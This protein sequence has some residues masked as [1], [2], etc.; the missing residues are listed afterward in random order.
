MPIVLS[1]C[2]HLASFWSGLKVV[3]NFEVHWLNSVDV[4]VIVFQL[5]MGALVYLF[6]DF[7]LQEAS[8]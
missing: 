2:K 3:L 8:M 4:S 1:A 7:F 5:Q 6:V